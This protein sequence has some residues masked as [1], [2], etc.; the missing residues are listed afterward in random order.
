MV[1]LFFGENRF[2]FGLSNTFF[3]MILLITASLMFTNDANRLVLRPAGRLRT[4]P[5]PK[6]LRRW[7]HRCLPLV[8]WLPSGKRL[9]SYGKIHHFKWGFINYQTISTGPFS[10]AFCLCTRGFLEGFLQKPHRTEVEKMI[11]RIE[12]FAEVYHGIVKWDSVYIYIYIVYIFVYTY[13][14][15]W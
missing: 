10:I 2:R 12:A 3:V 14:V 7:F 8:G 11:S 5:R 1:N 6:T 13:V 15:E 9:H 4:R